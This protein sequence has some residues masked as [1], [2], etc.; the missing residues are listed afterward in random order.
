[1]SWSVRVVTAEQ[2]QTAKAQALDCQRERRRFEQQ[3]FAVQRCAAR[4]AASLQH[5]GAV[6]LDASVLPE[7]AQEER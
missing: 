7:Q 2:Y 6:L 1:M 4:T 5:S 3:R